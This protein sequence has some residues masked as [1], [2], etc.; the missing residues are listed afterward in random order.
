MS[1]PDKDRVNRLV[2]E[3]LAENSDDAAVALFTPLVHYVL[4]FRLKDR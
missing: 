3:L 1:A 2:L 4:H